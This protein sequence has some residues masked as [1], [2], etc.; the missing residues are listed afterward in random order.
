[1][2]F[3]SVLCLLTAFPLPGEELS[4]SHKE[5]QQRRADLRKGLPDSLIV[6]FG[7]TE[8]SGGNVR[9]GFFQSSDFYYLTGW[10]EPNAVLVLTPSSETLFLPKRNEVQERWTG[11]KLAPGDPDVSQA[12][13]FD[14]VQPTTA[15]ESSLLK[16]SEAIPSIY[17]LTNTPQTDPL[18]RL[19]PLRDIRPA[20][21]LVARLRAK[22]SPAEIALIQRT[23][24]VTMDAHRAAWKRTEPGLNEY[25]IAATMGNVYFEAGCERHAYSPIVG[26]G[27]NA[28]VLHY[29]ENRRRMDAGELLLMDVAAECSMYASDI[30]RTIPVNGKFTPRQRE[31]YEIV[32]G[33]QK[34]AIAAIKPGVMLGHSSNKVGLHKV[35]LDYIDSHGKDLKGEKLGKYFIHGLGHHVGLDVHD[36][37]DPARPLEAG[38]V[39][40]IE[41]GIYIPEEKIGIR[42]EDVVLVT[43]DGAKVLSSALPREV[44]EIEKAMAR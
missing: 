27:P 29:S 20:N 32:L 37:N 18:R 5:Y 36:A 14:D 34:A 19:F 23:T 30:T 44:N 39:V 9:S 16:W 24:D 42:I 15:L 31:L 6:I 22:K 40:T 25:Q 43:E 26:S 10:R 3:V 1:M 8:Q 41:P 28:A 38:M 33:A 2:R 7:A 35:A 4:I 13:G 17:A 21:L 11:P 12:T